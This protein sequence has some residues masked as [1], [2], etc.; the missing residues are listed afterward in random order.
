MVSFKILL[1]QTY[2]VLLAVSANLVPLSLFIIDNDY[3]T[4]MLFLGADMSSTAFIEPLNVIDFVQELLNRDVS[5]RPLSDPE[6]IT[7]SDFSYVSF[8]WILRFSIFFVRF[9]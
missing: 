7:V 6:R 1:D 9:S 5:S 8:L 4:D 3:I 2:I